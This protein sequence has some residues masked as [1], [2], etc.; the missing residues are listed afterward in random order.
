[1]PMVKSVMNLNLSI[2]LF[3]A[4]LISTA[5]IAA[6]IAMGHG[7]ASNREAACAGAIQSAQTAAFARGAKTIT[8]INDCECSAA[9]GGTIWSC[10]ARVQYQ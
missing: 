4:F 9:V 1:M 5:A 10:I 2:A 7:T 8:S 3:A 6:G